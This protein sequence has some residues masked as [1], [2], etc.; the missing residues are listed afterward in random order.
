MTIALFALLGLL[1]LIV[2]HVAEYRRTRR[3]HRADADYRAAVMLLWA[4]QYAA[5]VRGRHVGQ[6]TEA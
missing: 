3:T 2:P 4:K 5:Q 1:A 6:G